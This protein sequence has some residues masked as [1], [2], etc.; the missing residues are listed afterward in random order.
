MLSPRQI[1]E[2]C[3]TMTVSDVL[4]GLYVASDGVAN[5][6][7][8]TMSLAKGARLNGCR[9]FEDTKVLGLDVE[10][11]CVSGVRTDRGRIACEIV[12]ICAGLWSRELGRNAGV[13]IPVLASHHQYMVTEKAAGL[14]RDMPSIRD[15]DRQ[16]Y[17]KE[18]V[19]GLVCGGYDFN[20]VASTRKPS[21]SDEEFKLFPAMVDH[22][23]QF[24]PAM[25]DRFPALQSTGVKKWFNG[26]E[27]F[28]EDT[29]FILGEAPEVRGVFVGCGFNA[30]GIAA[31]G[32]AGMALAHW[33]QHGASPMDL[34]PVDI[35]RFSE[36]HRSDRSVL[37]RS[38]EGQAHHYAMHWPY[39]ESRAGRPLRRSP[40]YDRLAA[41][42]A[43][44]GSKAG[45]ERPNWFAPEGVRGEDEYTFGRPN[46]FA[47]VGREHLACRESA[48]LFDQ[49][50]FAKFLVTGRDAEQALQRICAGDVGKSPGRITYTQMLNFQ[51]G[52]ECDLTVARV[53]EEEYYVVTGTAFATHDGMHLRRFVR[54]EEKI[55]VVDVT[56]AFGVLGLMGPK[57]RAILAQVAEADLSNNA[58]PFGQVKDI[59]VAGAP[60]RAMRV[61]FVG[62]LGWELHIPSEYMMTVYDALH[63]AGREHGLKN[64]G[65][66]AIDSLRLEK[67]LVV[68]GIDVGPDFTPLEA[69]LGFAVSFRKR[70]DFVGKEALLR[71]KSSLLTKR[72]VTFV[73]ADPEAILLGRET[74]YRNGQIV[75]WLSS[76]GF[77]FTVKKGIGLGYIRNRDGV[78]DEFIQS[79]HY[80]LEV[81]GRRVN[82][83]IALTPIY[84][85]AGERPRQ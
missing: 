17:F 25:I 59:I 75:G 36:Y 39:Y 77:G 79:G 35:R 54:P 2:L 22:F 33:M 34:W 20:P 52:I 61:T 43:C 6:S 4:C 23:E 51:G 1:A 19:G 28:T 42:G 69:G 38:L 80:E 49:S 48:C 84:D 45:W 29:N 41:S 12:A 30:M 46:W 73:V 5:P 13:N 64:A 65:Y 56:S 15:P 83:E 3:P 66:R 58:F 31:G 81:A 11:G 8:L 32:G 60:V 82:A 85:S 44:F 62:E 10:R 53:A 76:G 7:D 37:V 14:S 26:L 70:V 40:V 47:H 55:A 27:S 71:Q 24:M 78:S 72:L 63:A 67:S 16:T 57:A 50:S 74:I 18:E 21:F 9:I 68:W